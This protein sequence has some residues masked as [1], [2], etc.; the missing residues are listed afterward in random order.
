MEENKD[1]T[2]DLDKEQVDVEGQ[3]TCGPRRKKIWQINPGFHCAVIGSCLSRRDLR[4]IARKKIFSLEPGLD[5][6]ALHRSLSAIVSDRLPMTR[7]LNKFLDNKF[8]ASIKRYSILS[9][10]DQVRAEWKKDLKSRGE[11]SGAFWAIMT[12]PSC[13]K[14][15][16]EEVYGDCHMVSFDIFASYSRDA[17]KTANLSKQIEKLQHSLEKTKASYQKERECIRYE[18]GELQKR[19]GEFLRQ[20]LMNEHL[21]K[22]N[23]ELQRRLERQE[24]DHETSLLKKQLELLSKEKETLK[25]DAQT[26]VDQLSYNTNR[27]ERAELNVEHLRDDVGSLEV[28]NTELKEEIMSLEQMFQLGMGAK[29]VCDSCEEKHVNGCPRVGLTGKAVLYVGGRNNMITH[30]REM[31]EKHGGIFLHHDGGKESSR[32]LL[33]KMLSGADVVLCPIDCVSHDACKC[34]KKMCKRNCKPYVMMRS[35]GL[36]SLAKGLETVTQ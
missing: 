23:K 24:D 34:V 25:L 30:Y 5:S 20:R 3:G 6:F 26:N 28:L 12:M 19:K 31:V 13:G 27:A 9:S 33:P 2:I 7:A 17:K 29:T 1:S 15:L 36:S 32:H 11:I 21:V 8:R 16:L 10:D 14:E 4:L 35:S 22:E 18:L